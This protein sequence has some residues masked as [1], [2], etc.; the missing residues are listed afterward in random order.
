MEA[1]KKALPGKSVE[2]VKAT[3]V[4]DGVQPEELRN[5]VYDQPFD[6]KKKSDDSFLEEEV[7]ETVDDSTKVIYQAYSAPWPVSNRDLVILRSKRE[8]NGT[9]YQIDI[10]TTNAKKPDPTGSYVRADLIG[11]YKYEPCEEGTKATY[12]VF[13]DPMGMVPAF[14]V[15]SNTGKVP[16]RVEAFREMK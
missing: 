11:C 5:K 7:L 9:Y 12:L 4:I 16:K 13:M 6:E 10:S 3:G 14:V 1:W 2:V 15:N 8:E